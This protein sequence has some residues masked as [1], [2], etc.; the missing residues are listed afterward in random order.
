MDGREVD[1][2]AMECISGQGLDRLLAER[3]PS[4]AEALDI[5]LQIVEAVAAAHAA[6]IIHRDLK[7]ANVM[8]SDAGRV[9]VLD[10][11]L[12]KVRERPTRGRRVRR[13]RP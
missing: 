3:R 4:V 12:A 11:G 2:I 6:G 13:E 9:K 10:F 7:P 8:L 1:F 5:A